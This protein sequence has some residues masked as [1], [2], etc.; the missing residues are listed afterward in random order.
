MFYLATYAIE[1]DI[2]EGEQ[3]R[4]CT[5][6]AP[7]V[8]RRAARKV[9]LL[10][11]ATPGPPGGALPAPRSLPHGAAAGGGSAPGGCEGG[12]AVAGPPP[13][14][15]GTAGWLLAAVGGE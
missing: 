8:L 2:A 13:R 5:E 6:P 15:G 12:P 7:R 4:S 3:A 9:S 14:P 11:P 10:L 1:V